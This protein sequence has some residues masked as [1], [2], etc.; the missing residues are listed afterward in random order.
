MD[1]LGEFFGKSVESS[2]RGAEYSS[3]SSDSAKS[4]SLQQTGQNSNPELLAEE[5]PHEAFGLKFIFS[6]GE[7]T[8]FETLPISIGRGEN[9]DLVIKDDT[10]SLVHALIYFD[11]RVQDVCIA[12][13]SSLNG[14]LIDQ[15]PTRC[16]VLHDG[17]KISVGGT[18]ISFR[19]TGYIHAH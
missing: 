1:K 8:L 4:E 2:Q 10:V 14:L 6:S 15:F 5:T 3:G 13:Q 16:N 18:S 19:D 7:E 12:D 17:V 11:E 9:N